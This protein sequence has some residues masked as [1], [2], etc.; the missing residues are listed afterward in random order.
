M[1]LQ[2]ILQP[3]VFDDRTKIEYIGEPT[4]CRRHTTSK[5]TACKAFINLHASD[6]PIALPVLSSLAQERCLLLCQSQPSQRQHQLH[7]TLAAV[8]DGGIT[9]ILCQLHLICHQSAGLILLSPHR[10][11]QCHA[12][13]LLGQTPGRQATVD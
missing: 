12:A 10:L 11:P 6:R 4:A 1:N 5:C 13:K 9:A 2:R 3:A 8:Y 7:V